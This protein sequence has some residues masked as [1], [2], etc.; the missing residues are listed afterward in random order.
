MDVNMNMWI[1]QW[2]DC[3]GQIN[4]SCC[5]LGLCVCEEDMNNIQNVD[6]EINRLELS[7]TDLWEMDGAGEQD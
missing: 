5:Y 2:F 7:F 6:K 4:S 3:E 1:K